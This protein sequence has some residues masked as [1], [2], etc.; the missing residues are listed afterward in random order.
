MDDALMAYEKQLRHLGEG[1]T[2]TLSAELFESQTTGEGW[3][4]TE[5]PVVLRLEGN[6]LRVIAGAGYLAFDADELQRELVKLKER[7]PQE[8]QRPC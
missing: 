3:Y 5:A 1:P 4:D 8:K 6:R 2:T 7:Q